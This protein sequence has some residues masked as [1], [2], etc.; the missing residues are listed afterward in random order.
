MKNAVYLI[1]FYVLFFSCANPVAPTGGAKDEEPPKVKYI[2]PINGITNYKGNKVEIAFDEYFTFSKSTEKILI[3]PPVSKDPNFQVKGKKLLIQFKEPLEENTTYTINILGAVSDFHEGNVLDNVSYVFSTGSFIDSASIEGK[4]VNAYNNEGAEKVTVLLYEDSDTAILK[5]GRPNYITKTTAGGSFIIRNVKE[6]AY[7]LLAIN[8]KN[9]NNQFDQTSEEVSIISSRIELSGNVMLKDPVILFKNTEE[10]KVLGY[11][12][13]SN[14]KIYFYFS[15]SIDQLAINSSLFSENDKAYL[16]ESKDTLFYYFNSDSTNVNFYISLN[17]NQNDTIE[18]NLKKNMANAPIHLEQESLAWKD[19]ISL[20]FPLFIDEVNTDKIHLMDTAGNELP[21]KV[22]YLNEK[23]IV[24]YP[25]MPEL[26]YNLLFD[27]CVVIYFDG[28]CSEIYKK[29]FVKT[30]PIQASQ[31]IL[32][33]NNSNGAHNPVL[34]LY[35]KD[36]LIDKVT[37]ES[38]TSITFSDMLPKQY[39]IRVFD[40]VNNNGKWDSGNFDLQI[41]PEKTLFY[42]QPI[43]IKENWDKELTI[44]F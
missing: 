6:G 5:G 11:K 10:P 37:V 23:V 38:K 31:L 12:Q 34:E 14:N 39:Q 36:K 17:D 20:Q 32:T 40:D 25:F 16:N 15:E 19:S 44:T 13:L 30:T 8:D 18:V 7:Q 1:L 42:S 27:S 28:T 3:T 9:Y 26:S 33:I 24:Y 43:D 29:E 21:L 2:I 4:V 22:K 41:E 35:Q